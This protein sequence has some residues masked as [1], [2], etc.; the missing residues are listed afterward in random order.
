MIVSSVL[1]I[2]NILRGSKNTF[3]LNINLLSQINKVIHG[4]SK[5]QN[6]SK[7]EIITKKLFLNNSFMLKNITVTLKR[8]HQI[9]KKCLNVNRYLVDRVL[10]SW[11]HESVFNLV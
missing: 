9:T 1:N 4:K 6:Q 7:N 10:I 2:N 5:Y 11:Q 3:P 8:L